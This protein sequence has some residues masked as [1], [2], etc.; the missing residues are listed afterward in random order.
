[1]WNAKPNVLLHDEMFIS[2]YCSS[3]LHSQTVY[4]IIPSASAVI[5]K[6]SGGTEVHIN[7]R[8][9]FTWLLVLL[10]GSYLRRLQPQR[11]ALYSCLLRVLLQQ[12]RHCALYLWHPYSLVG[13]KCLEREISDLPVWLTDNIINC[14]VYYFFVMFV[15]VSCPKQLHTSKIKQ[16]SNLF[17]FSYTLFI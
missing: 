2:H 12:R 16:Y 13:K 3:C 1:M 15:A 7:S 9:F 17:L 4:K 8:N 11:G 6:T 5:Y 10:D 14:I